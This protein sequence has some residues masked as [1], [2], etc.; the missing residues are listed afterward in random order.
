M[1]MLFYAFCI[2]LSS[3]PP[4]LAQSNTITLDREEWRYIRDNIVQIQKDVNL[5]QGGIN[6]QAETMKLRIAM[7]DKQLEDYPEYQKK[8]D[9]LLNE[10]DLLGRYLGPIISIILSTVI[11]IIIVNQIVRRNQS[12]QYAVSTWK[13]ARNTDQSPFETPRDE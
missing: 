12:K 4:V 3:V 11:P 10:K 5:I 9:T 8:V 13:T 2:L 6:T 1:R 7:I